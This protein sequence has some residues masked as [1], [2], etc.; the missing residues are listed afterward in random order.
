MILVMAQ[1][2][3]IGLGSK[4]SHLCPGEPRPLRYTVITIKGSTL[5]LEDQYRDW[6]IMDIGNFTP[7]W[8]F[9]EVLKNA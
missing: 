8:V 1:L 6:L 4:I 7:D 9:G 3:L 5:T 2:Q